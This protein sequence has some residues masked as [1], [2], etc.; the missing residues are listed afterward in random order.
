M[1]Y[2]SGHGGRKNKRLSLWG[3]LLDNPPDIR[4]K[5]FVKHMVGFVQNQHFKMIEIDI[6]AVIKIK[7][8]SWTGNNDL[9][10]GANR[11]DLAATASARVLEHGEGRALRIGQHREAAHLRDVG[12]LA[13]DAR[14]EFPGEFHRR[15]HVRDRDVR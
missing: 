15:V 1:F 8:S 7:Q 3:Q 5:S 9:G 4:K 10:T 6:T 2:F 14:T 12:G 13:V 11:P